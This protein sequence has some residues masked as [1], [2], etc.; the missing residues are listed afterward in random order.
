MEYL[1]KS[2]SKLPSP[3]RSILEFALKA[4]I[5]LL[6][7]LVSLPALACEC[8]WQG[9]FKSVYEQADL[10]VYGQVTGVQGNGFDLQIAKT[11]Q[12]SD[13]REQIRVWTK[14]GDLCRP[15]IDQFPADSQWVLALQRIDKPPEGSFNPFKPNISYGRQDDYSLSS[16]GVYWLP[17]KEQRVSGNILDGSRWQYVDPKKTPVIMAIFEAWLKNIL[18]DEAL[19]EAAR[20]QTAARK[21]LNNTKIFLW[22]DQRNQ[23]PEPEVDINPP[24]RLNI[25]DSELDKSE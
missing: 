24:P 5:S 17:V 20:L 6:S 13:Y 9:P 19:A 10:I 1:A 16:C 11:L 15:D 23:G 7:L 2:R 21:L 18:P 14:T 12:G 22:E 8:L 4:L 3:P 25:D